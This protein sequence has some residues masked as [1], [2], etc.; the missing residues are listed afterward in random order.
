MQAEKLLYLERALKTKRSGQK[1][2][3]RNLVL[4]RSVSAH[5]VGGYVCVQCVKGKRDL[6]ASTAIAYSNVDL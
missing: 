3:D 4:S 1:G 5:A 6:D 2:K